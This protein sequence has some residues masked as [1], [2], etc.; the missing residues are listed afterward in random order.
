MEKN[1]IYTIAATVLVVLVMISIVT[2]IA[3]TK[4]VSVIKVRDTK[5]KTYEIYT[6]AEI[7]AKLK[8]F[9]INYIDPSFCSQKDIYPSIKGIN[10]LS[11]DCGDDEVIGTVQSVYCSNN[12]IPYVSGVGYNNPDWIGLPSAVS[13][14]CARW[15]NNTSIIEAPMSITSQCCMIKKR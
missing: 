13:Y 14:S 10:F 12:G 5:L 8:S 4:I 7:D 2:A 11:F 3:A 9:E 15:T 6:K 1:Q